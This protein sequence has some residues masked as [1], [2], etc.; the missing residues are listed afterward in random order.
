MNTK[1]LIVTIFAVITALTGC[2]ETTETPRQETGIVMDYAGSEHCSFIIEL[3][4]G[5]QIQPFHYPDE[6]T[7]TQ[8]QRVLIRY[9]KLPNII[10]TCDQGVACDILHVEEID[11][12]APLT[13]LYSHNSDSLANDPVYL[14]EAFIDGNCL[15]LKLSFSGGCREHTVDLARI[16]SLEENSEDTVELEIRHNA[17]DDPCEAFL[18]KTLSFDLTSLKNDGIT[19]FYLMANLGDETYKKLFE[20]K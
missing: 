17:N 1:F 10:P 3:D 14:Q 5:E 4:N 6:F 9:V 18:T 2:N 13:D 8:G 19:R 7:F 16:H 12:G 11:C 20:L 15:N